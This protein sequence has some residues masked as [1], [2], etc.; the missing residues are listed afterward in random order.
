[1]FVLNETSTRRSKTAFRLIKNAK[2]FQSR[3][4]QVC[5]EIVWTQWLRFIP[6]VTL[7]SETDDE[8]DACSFVPV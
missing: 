1:M 4:S 3:F 5:I 7:G 2:L 6:R 8:Y